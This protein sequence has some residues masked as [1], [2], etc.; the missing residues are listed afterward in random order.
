MTLIRSFKKKAFGFKL[1]TVYG[2]DPGGWGTTDYVRAAEMS[3]QI[4]RDTEDRNLLE[5]YFGASE[6]LVAARRAR[7]TIKTEFAGSGA[8]GT[9]PAWGRLMRACGFAETVF[10]GSRVEYTPVTDAPESATGHWRADGTRFTSRGMRGTVSLM[11]E[12]FKL[13]YLKFDLTGFDTS[14]LAEAMPAMSKAAWIAGEVMTDAI[15]ADL[16]VGGTYAAGSVTGGTVHPMRTLTL[17]VG[18]DIQHLKLTSA[19]AIHMGDRKVT[20]NVTLAMSAA[21]EITWRSEINANTNRS[22]GMRWGSAAG[23][24]CGF[25][26]PNVQR[27]APQEVDYQG[28]SLVQSDLIAIPLTGNDELR[29]WVA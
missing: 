28:R 19:E 24:F 9:P 26:A 20:G 23:R 3:F 18:N 2:T 10:A 7:V 17:N 13:P 22:I 27:V 5:P 4:E 11:L 15:T 29:L 16:R 1:E 21:D 6:S 8:A 14:A 25:F 12:A